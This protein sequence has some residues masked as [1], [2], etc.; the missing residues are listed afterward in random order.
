MTQHLRNKVEEV[1]RGLNLINLSKAAKSLWLLFSSPSPCNEAAVTQP[2][3][4]GNS[5]PRK[6]L[7]PKK[8]CPV[9][10]L[11]CSLVAIY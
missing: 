1:G 7:E 4:R 10:A 5:T 11:R 2:E 9:K 3:A 6:L 8:D